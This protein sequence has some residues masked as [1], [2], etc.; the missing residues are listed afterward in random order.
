M[1]DFA[2]DPPTPSP[3]EVEGVRLVG[4]ALMILCGVCISMFTLNRVLRRGP[5]TL[6]APCCGCNRSPQRFFRVAYS[7]HG[8]GQLGATTTST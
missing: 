6:G 4:S 2:P 7:S 3:I 1:A 8:G 5:R